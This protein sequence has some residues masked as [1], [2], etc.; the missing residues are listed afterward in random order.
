MICCGCGEET[1]TEVLLTTSSSAYAEMELRQFP[2][3]EDGDV[4]VLTPRRL[5]TLIDKMRGH[6]ETRKMEASAQVF[7]S[8]KEEPVGKPEF[9]VAIKKS[10]FHQTVGLVLGVSDGASH[11]TVKEVREG[12]ISRWNARETSQVLPGDVIVDVNGKTGNRD[13][14]LAIQTESEL[15]IK[16][17]RG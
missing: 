13:I 4:E 7:P 10:S 16:L 17:R 2:L 1:R 14:L 3:N 5:R 9:C 8:L 12:L 11:L 15:K 6:T